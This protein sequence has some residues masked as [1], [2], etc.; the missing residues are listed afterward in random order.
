[1]NIHALF[2]ALRQKTVDSGPEDANRSQDSRRKGRVGCL[3]CNRS[4]RLV[5]TGKKKTDRRSRRCLRA[6]DTMT[7]QPILPKLWPNRRK[8]RRKRKERY[9]LPARQP[10][11]A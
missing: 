6:N 4:R 2:L 3:A 11:G 5:S 10:V 7:A 9:L 8:M 1:M